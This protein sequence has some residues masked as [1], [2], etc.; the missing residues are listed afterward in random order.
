MTKPSILIV[1]DEAIV[2]KDLAVKIQQLGY[3]VAGITA[4]GA[5]AI[6]LARQQ[7]PELVLMDI[8]LTGTMDGI[9]AAQVIHSECNLSVLFLT[10]HSDAD[11]TERA[12]QAGAV[13]YI[14]KPFDER[15]LRIQ[16]EMAFYKHAAEQRLR[17]R[18][19][20]LTAINQILQAALIC[21]TEEELGRTC[22]D[23]AEKITQSKMGF[24][25][26]I[27]QEGLADIAMSNPSWETCNLSNP[28]AIVSNQEALRFMEFTV[29]SYGTARVCSPMIQRITRTASACLQTILR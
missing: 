17:Q 11:T 25:G 14:L 28:T 23:I 18:D 5:E 2:A 26:D 15:D 9:A 6:E 8:R 10:A 19:D 3:H 13:G 20:R 27:N 12:Q 4:T 7:R 29:G 22:L 24:I 1:E 16:I 21:A